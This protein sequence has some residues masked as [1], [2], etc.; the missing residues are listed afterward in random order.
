MF[1]Q[2]LATI[3]NLVICQQKERNFTIC[4]YISRTTVYVAICQHK[5]SY[6]TTFIFSTLTRKISDY[7][8]GSPIFSNS[9][10]TGYMPA[11]S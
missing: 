2:Y 5:G 3:L 11:L 8:S 9:T 10:R 4:S 6:S 1:E 7:A